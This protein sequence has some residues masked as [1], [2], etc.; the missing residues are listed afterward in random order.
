[1]FRFSIFAEPVTT[2]IKKMR[3]VTTDLG[4]NLT[5]RPSH[6]ANITNFLQIKAKYRKNRHFILGK[7]RL[8]FIAPVIPGSNMHHGARYPK[9]QPKTL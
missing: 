8:F 9:K 2:E 1:M 6:N 5:R 7:W 3:P 4:A